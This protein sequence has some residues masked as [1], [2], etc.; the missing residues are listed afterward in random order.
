MEVRK[1]KGPSKDLTIAKHMYVGRLENEFK[2]NFGLKV[3]IFDSFDKYHCDQKISLAEA[4][5]QCN[6]IKK[7]KKNMN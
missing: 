7:Q 2:K 4:L 6:A 1:N 3:L 5:R